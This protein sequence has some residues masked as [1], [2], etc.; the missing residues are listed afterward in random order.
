[1]NS[2]WKEMTLAEA[3]VILIDCVHKTP[4]SQIEGIPYIGIPQLNK[5]H[6][7]FEANPR[8]IS[9]EDYIEWTK[10]ANPKHN[11]VILSRRTNPG[12]TAHVPIN[13]KFA[14]GQNLVIMRSIGKIVYPP[15][16]RWLLRGPDW[17]NQI[18]KFLNVGAIFDSLRCGDIPNFVLKIPPYDEQI[19]ISC[20]LNNMDDKIEL[21][22]QMNQTLEAM[23]QALFK[24]W[25]VD[26][27]PVL[28]NVLEAG[29]E[30]PEALQAM[31]DKRQLV[32]NSKKLLHTNPALAAQF[33]SS[34]VFNEVLD[35]WIPEG[36]ENGKLGDRYFVK[37]GFAFKSKDFVEENGTPVVK[38]KSIKGDNS[39]DKS[40]LSMVKTS[41]AIQ[42]EDFWLKNGDIL[43]AMTGATVG[44]FG[45]VVKDKKELIVLNQ[46][47]AKFYCRSEKLKS[48][49]FVYSFFNDSRNTDFIVN[50]AS[51]SAQP[52]ISANEIMSAPMILAELRLI[53]KFE[54]IVS[55]K[56]QRIIQ[57]QNQIETL[58]KLRDNLLPELMSGRVRVKSLNIIL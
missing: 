42:R 2:G 17:W 21:N 9:E 47:V 11:D 14:L 19:S 41:V 28:D 43:M 38:I 33:P 10:K 24:S 13:K 35:K 52:N 50:T 30:I 32:P 15:Y 8:L 57:N 20:I 40:D 44:K 4:I 26:F 53:Q 23:A 58:T 5:G 18:S 25:F 3:E 12:V 29:N 51:G 48:I 27:N 22:R 39:V 45:V 1:M 46:R 6:I 37:G 31:A 36:W 55:L 16:L 56:F 7:D 34:F 54:E 49:W